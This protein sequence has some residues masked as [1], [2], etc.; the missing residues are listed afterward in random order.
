MLRRISRS[1]HHPAGFRFKLSGRAAPGRALEQARL[2]SASSC[3]C[4]EPLRL[5]DRLTGTAEQ[6]QARLKPLGQRN[7]DLGGDARAPPLITTRSP[8]AS[9]PGAW[10]FRP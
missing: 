10:P 5:L 2:S 7:G 4:G 6:D 1:S 3:S 8:G 9:G